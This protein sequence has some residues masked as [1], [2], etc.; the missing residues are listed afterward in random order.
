[1]VLA[2]VSFLDPQLYVTDHLSMHTSLG[3]LVALSRGS[4]VVYSHLVWE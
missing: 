2:I 3:T 1:M 4:V